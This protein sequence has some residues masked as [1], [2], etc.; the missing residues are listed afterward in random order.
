MHRRGVDAR[1]AVLARRGAVLVLELDPVRGGA[2]E[3]VEGAD[4]AHAEAAEEQGAVLQQPGRDALAV[5]RRPAREVEAV[6][7][8][9]DRE[10]DRPRV[11]RTALDEIGPRGADRAPPGGLGQAR[12]RPGRTLVV[13]R[14]GHAPRF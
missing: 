10:G 2:D 12:P 6:D 8:R 7:G 4:V 3:A 9:P 5:G 14:I 11:Q 13:A 1:A